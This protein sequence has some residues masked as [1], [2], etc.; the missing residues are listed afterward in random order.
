VAT[1]LASQ[2]TPDYVVDAV[3]GHTPQKLKRTYNRYQPVREMRVWLAVWSSELE[4][5]VAGKAA[6]GDVVPLVRANA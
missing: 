5:I 6:R 4:R 2:G 1:G 3:L